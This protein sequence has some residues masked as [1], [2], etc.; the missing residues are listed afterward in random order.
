[1]TPRTLRYVAYSLAAHLFLF[2]LFAVSMRFER[3][4]HDMQPGDPNAV[5]AIAIDETPL[6]EAAEREEEEARAA[7]E[8]EAEAERQRQA[9]AEAE[10]Q[11]QLEAERQAEAEA[12]AEAERQRQLEAERQA[13]A[14]REAE[15]QRQLEA[16]RQAEA[17]REAERQR[18]R[19]EAERARR[20]AE[21]QARREAEA[22]AA[23]QAEREAAAA[24]RRAAQARGTFD[25]AI[26]QKIRRAWTRPAGTP[27]GLSAV[28]LVRL[29]P[30]GTVLSVEITRS[31]G[32][33]SFD[34][35]AETA[36]LRADPLPMPDDP[37]LARPYRQGV[38]LIFNPDG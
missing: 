19:E 10:R 23:E 4:V 30:G 16:E 21:E 9:E 13:E 28:V 32:N 27:E 34:R 12:E 2:G 1:M 14:E 6:I 11:R 38:E 36:V 22:E 17:E 29:G 35:S 24:A 20:E 25:A 5:Q 3:P 15:R 7:A 33:A 8:A 31:S 37:L 26:Q 18:Q